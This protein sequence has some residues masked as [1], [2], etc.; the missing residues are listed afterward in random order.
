[1]GFVSNSSASSFI[2]KEKDFNKIECDTCKALLE[3]VLPKQRAEDF[4]E[5]HWI[6]SSWATYKKEYGFDKND[7]IYANHINHVIIKYYGQY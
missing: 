4:M 6:C 1:M 7:F 5:K 3:L 2:V